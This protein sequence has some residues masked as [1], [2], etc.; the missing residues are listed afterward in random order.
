MC[1]ARV[2]VTGSRNRRVNGPA[3]DYAST[4]KT[5]RFLADRAFDANWVREALA[6]ARIEAVIPTKSNRRF[7]ADFDRDTYKWRLRL[8][9]L[10][11]ASLQRARPRGFSPPFLCVLDCDRRHCR[12]WV[13]WVCGSARKTFRAELDAR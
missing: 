8:A 1:P 10:R 5:D 12:V 11:S 9:H 13:S 7:T 4:I 6:K 2:P 3:V